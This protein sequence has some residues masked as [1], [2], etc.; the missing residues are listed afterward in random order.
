MKRLT[1]IL[2]E[3]DSAREGGRK[4]G[5]EGE[6]IHSNGTIHTHTNYL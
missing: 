1:P 3:K 5:R 6:V 2:R 4:G